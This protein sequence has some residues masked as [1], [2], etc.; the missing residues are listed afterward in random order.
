MS[1]QFG[2][3]NFDGEAID[4]EVLEQVRPLIAPY[5]PD[6][7]GGYARTISDCSIERFTPPRNRNLN[8]NRASCLLGQ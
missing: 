6:D 1:V 8:V 7:E 2:K 5:G 3:V 4:P